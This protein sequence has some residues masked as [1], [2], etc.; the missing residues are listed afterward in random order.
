MWPFNPSRKGSNALEQPA[1]TTAQY[2]CRLMEEQNSLL[3]ELIPALSGHAART[4]KTAKQLPVSRIRTDKDVF[5]VDR[6][7]VLQQERLK[8]EQELAPWWSTTGSGPA[9]GS[10][11]TP[12]PGN[13]DGKLPAA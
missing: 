11:S 7:T 13:G 8:Q 10:S 1:E 3:R 6:N 12:T 4:L 5:R 9:S 2:L